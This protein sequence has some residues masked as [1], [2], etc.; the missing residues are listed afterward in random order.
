MCELLN[1]Q[2]GMVILAK[3]TGG[4]F[5][6]GHNDIDR[7]LETV[8]DDGNGYYLIGYQPDSKTV[9][10]MKKGKPKAHKIQVR[11]KRPGF[12]GPHHDPSFSALRIP[13]PAGNLIARQQQVEKAFYSPFKSE[14][15][16]VRLT[17]LFSQ[18][19]DEKS[20]INA[21]LH[22]D[23]NQLVF[24]DEPDGW[25]KATIE[26]TAGLY[27]ADG[28]QVDF[29]DKTWNLTAKG[30]TYEYMQ[31][32]G[33]AFLMNVPVKQP[34]V[35]QMRLVLRDTANGQLGSATQ[36]IEVPNVR[37]GKLAL[38]GI[39]LAADKSKS[40]AAVDQAEGVIEEADS[41]KTAPC[42]SSNPARLSRGRTRSSM[43]KAARTT[44]RS[45][46]RR[47][48]CSVKVGRLTR[49]RRLAMNAQAQE[50]SKRMIAADQIHLKQLP[51]GYYVLQIAVT[52]MLAKEG[53]RTAVQS[54]DFDA[55]N[56]E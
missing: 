14:D 17:G 53:Q 16:R 15:L 33:I 1:S 52:D 32:N 43:R 46:W 8:A 26:I 38:S 41:K 5:M 54:I 20:V 56:P 18:T 19:K 11:V 34:G 2:D 51:P 27:G 12:D 4:L 48:G 24:S 23:A 10:E 42:A 22:F 28:Q 30:K 55:Q 40:E 44:S 45:W 25:H 13:Q 47:S 21:L 6:A 50:D 39:L 3:Q 35:Y 9:S 37:D 36:V 29:A 7:V 49:E 31:K